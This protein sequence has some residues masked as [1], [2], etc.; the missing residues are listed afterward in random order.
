MYGLIVGTGYFT[1]VQAQNND[2]LDL[3]S[4]VIFPE[5]VNVYS[6]LGQKPFVN[7]DTGYSFENISELPT[8]FEFHKSGLLAWFPTPKEFKELKNKSVTIVFEAHETTGNSTKMG[9]ILISANDT[10][11]PKEEAEVATIDTRNIDVKDTLDI[12]LPHFNG[13]NEK[14]EGDLFSFTIGA[15]GGTGG[16]RFQAITEDDINYTFDNDGTFQ[17][18]PDYSY[19]DGKVTLRSSKITFKVEDMKGNKDSVVVD[20][21]VHNTNR[22]P[23]VHELPTFY[24]QWDKENVFNLN[25]E[26]IV[27]DEDKD[28]IVFK[29]ILS[30]MPQGMTLTKEGEVKW[31][32]SVSQFYQLREQPLKL[33][34]TVLDEPHGHQTSATARFEVTQQ[35][36]PPQLTMVPATDMIEIDENEAL[37]LGFFINDPNGIEDVAVFNFVSDNDEVETGSLTSVDPMQYEF[38]WVPDYSFVQERGES[39]EFQITFYAFD[40]ENNRTEKQIRVKVNDAENIEEEDR[41]LYFQYRTVLATA[42]E[43]VEQLSEKEDELKK[44][45]K[46]AK[47]G[48]KNRAIA[49]AS[50]GALT[51]LSPIFLEGQ[52]QKVTVGIGGTATATIGTLEA[53]NVIGNPP[54]DIMQRWSYVTSKK[55][56]ILLYGNIFAGKYAQK[57]ERRNNS[58]QNDLK[59]LTFQMNLQ[60][61]TKLELD[62]SWQGT[63]DPSDRNIKK[64]FKD[65]YPDKEY[66]VN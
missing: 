40:K 42:F 28:P 23:V 64:L 37:N 46:H 41:R 36:L 25:L 10:E 56:E 49:N 21:V 3:P 6:I 59:N 4:F 48:K 9:K 66:D 2:S 53:S 58:F 44:E 8:G 29:P 17:W 15:S 45:Y 13:W 38:K 51:G 5:K 14:K 7:S 54:A 39:E 30:E 1:D 34:F 47:G 65:F 31:R 24:V 55:N 26:G 52:T 60:D 50:L 57:S 33:R 20:L 18:S 22:P 35:D 19:V 32:P 16:Y 43:L 63:K 27:Y 11:A 61:M 12:K 62:A